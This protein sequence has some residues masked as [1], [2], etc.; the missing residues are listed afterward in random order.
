MLF[1]YLHIICFY[2]IYS[3]YYN[4]SNIRTIHNIQNKL[5]IASSTNVCAKT[6]ER[7]F[8]RTYYISNAFVCL[9]VCSE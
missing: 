3:T 4:T 8:E 5:R 9:F 1:N 2:Y 6:S 7:H